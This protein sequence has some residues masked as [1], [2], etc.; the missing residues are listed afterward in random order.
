MSRFE[1]ELDV[2]FGEDDEI[3]DKHITVKGNKNDVKELMREL[4]E[5]LGIQACI[6][7]RFLLLL[8][9]TMG[10]SVTHS[11]ASVTVYLT[12]AIL[13]RIPLYH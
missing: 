6:T 7:A 8:S 5:K 10:N 2:P 9:D 1:V 12:H 13:A 4:A 11:L 3:A